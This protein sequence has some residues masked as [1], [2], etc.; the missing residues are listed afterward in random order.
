[1]ENAVSR[2]LRS[3]LLAT[4]AVV[5]LGSF[6]ANCGFVVREASNVQP[7]SSQ[8]LAPVAEPGEEGFLPGRVTR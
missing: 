5:L 3:T 4:A 8:A 7:V 1:M 6:G 2:R